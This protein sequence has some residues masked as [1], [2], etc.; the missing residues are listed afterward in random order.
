VRYFCLSNSA[1][2]RS[3]RRESLLDKQKAASTPR[4]T[5]RKILQAAAITQSISRK[6]NCWDNAPMESFFG[7]LKTELVHQRE[8]PD[9]EA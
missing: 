3:I 8:Y 5:Y 6:A 2:R 1:R 9:R 4:A 7:T